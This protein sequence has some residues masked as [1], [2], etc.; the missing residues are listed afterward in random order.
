MATVIS[1]YTRDDGH[2]IAVYESGAE[3]DKTAKR[4]AKAPEKYAITAEN[5]SEYKRRRQE[6]Q[7]AALRQRILEVTQ[8]HSDLPLS[9]S[10]EAVAEAGAFLWDEI[11][12]GEDVYPR[13]RLEAWERIG[14]HAG[15]LADRTDKA[16]EQAQDSAT[17]V[18]RQVASI[19]ASLASVA[20]SPLNIMA[21]TPT[22]EGEVIDAQTT[23]TQDTGEGEAG[24]G[25]TA[26]G[27]G[28]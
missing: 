23:G 10:A 11:V 3:Y 17:E 2:V 27:G 20:N 9:D 1:E 25:D 22:H 4:L 26:G 6:K 13:D 5:T 21:I 16:Q 12:L 8:K 28:G 24:E 18:L 15:I 19:A 7:Q 14:K